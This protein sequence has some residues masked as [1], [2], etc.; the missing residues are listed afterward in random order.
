MEQRKRAHGDHQSH[1]L[2]GGS[3]RSSRSTL[4]LQA[5]SP[6]TCK[7]TGNLKLQLCGV[8]ALVKGLA[9]CGWKSISRHN[10]DAHTGQIHSIDRA[11]EKRYWHLAAKASA[12]NQ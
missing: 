12:R 5:S 6:H 8:V 9:M 4:E 11:S 3:R 1:S 2:R 10:L 7:F